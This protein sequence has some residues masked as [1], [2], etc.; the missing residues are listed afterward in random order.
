MSSAVRSYAD[1][2]WRQGLEERVGSE[3]TSAP[4][5]QVWHGPRF[6]IETTESVMSAD[7][8]I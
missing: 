5:S 1:A 7:K 6:L 3:G 4:R 8:Q 2:A